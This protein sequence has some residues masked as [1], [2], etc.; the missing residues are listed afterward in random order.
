MDSGEGP[1]NVIPHFS[2]ILANFEFSCDVWAIPEGTP[3][4]PH[5]RIHLETDEE[6]LDLFTDYEAKAAAEKEET[7]ELAEEKRRQQA[8]LDIKKKFGKNAILKGMNFEEGAT[9]LINWSIG[10]TQIIGKVSFADENGEEVIPPENIGEAEEV[11]EERV[12]DDDYIFFKNCKSSS[13]QTIFKSNILS[14]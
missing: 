8:I 11:S 10:N 14:P 2:Q 6:Q 9:E 1:I 13:S 12:G 3:I 5:E 7:A 4:F